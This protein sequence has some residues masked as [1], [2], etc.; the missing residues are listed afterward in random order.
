MQMSEE[1]KTTLSAIDSMHAIRL[2]CRFRLPFVKYD[3][4][5]DDRP[6]ADL[7]LSTSCIINKKTTCPGDK[8]RISLA[9]SDI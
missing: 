7:M 2:L 1:K 6:A 9:R 3:T 8:E 4:K 5:D